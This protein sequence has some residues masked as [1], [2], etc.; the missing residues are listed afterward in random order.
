MKSFVQFVFVVGVASFSSL[1]YSGSTDWKARL[2]N[3]DVV[4]VNLKDC[5][6]NIG[7]LKCGTKYRLDY[8]GDANRRCERVTGHHPKG[9]NYT[10]SGYCNSNP[11]G[12]TISLFGAKFTYTPEGDVYS[13]GGGAGDSGTKVGKL[14]IP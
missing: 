8:S 12:Q 14:E 10:F 5:S 3:G 9:S 6:G 7:T 11:K 1:V 2:I 4:V 13:I